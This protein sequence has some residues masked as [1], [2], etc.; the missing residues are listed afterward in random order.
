MATVAPSGVHAAT[1]VAKGN[2]TEVV[3]TPV[4][5]DRTTT[6]V[7]PA[8]VGLRYSIVSPER[9]CDEVLAIVQIR[10]GARGFVTSYRSAVEAMSGYSLRPSSTR[11]PPAAG[12]P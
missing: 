7:V 3:S 2:V 4:A 11:E 1:P 5:M 6:S 9:R 8:A 10:R 12:A